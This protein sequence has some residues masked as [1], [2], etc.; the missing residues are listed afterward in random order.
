GEVLFRRGEMDA[1]RTQFETAIRIRSERQRSR[2]DFPLAVMHSSL[3]SVLQ[4]EQ[5]MEEALAHF[6]RAIQLQPDYGQ[7]YDNLAATLAEIGRPQEALAVLRQATAEQ[8]ENA[9]AHVGIGTLLLQAGSEEEAVAAY[10]KALAIAPRAT[11]ALNNLAWLYA[12]SRKPSLHNPAR[13]LLL[14]EQAVSASTEKD[15]FLLHK[16]AAAYAAN[17]RFPEAVQTAE[18][19]LQL[20]LT[21]NDADLAGELKRNLAL[22]RSGSPIAGVPP[23]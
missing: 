6:R 17:G 4:R 1:A 23:P 21:R 13:A 16:L 12:T 22:Y 5:R 20:A 7:A 9:G 10:E 11:T 15:P 14:A 8:P 19:A 18:H 3:G 2:Y